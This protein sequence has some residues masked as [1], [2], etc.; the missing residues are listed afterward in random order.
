MVDQDL[1]LDIHPVRALVT[2]ATSGI[3]R[4]TVVEVPSG[5]VAM[6]SHP[7]D[8]VR[9]TEAAAETVLVAS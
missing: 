8:V 6:V 9:L 7:G 3:G 5:H 2:G 1:D 4:A